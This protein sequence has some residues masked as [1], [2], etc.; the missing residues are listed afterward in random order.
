MDTLNKH[1]ARK[2]KIFFNNHKPHANKALRSV[3]MEQS[4]LTTVTVY[5]S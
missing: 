1:A 4:A 2:T 5:K 3:I